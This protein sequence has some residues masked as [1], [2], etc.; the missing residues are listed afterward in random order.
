VSVSADG[1]PQVVGRIDAGLLVYV[2]VAPTDTPA[3]A[4]KLADK[5]AHL[6]ILEDADGKMNRSV[7]DVGGGI[8]AVPNFTLL[9]DARKGRRP[10]FDGAARPE[11][12]EP[13]FDAF[14]DALRGQGCTVASGQFGAHMTIRSDAAG[15]VN[16]V[17]EMP[18]AD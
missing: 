10:A 17:V 3:D 1:A 11:S 2:G 16:L 18:P 14:L 13:L 4:E 12:A 6:R 8:L 9:A 5:L 7:R 15:P